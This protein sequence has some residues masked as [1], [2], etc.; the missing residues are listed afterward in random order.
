MPRISVEQYSFEKGQLSARFAN[1]VETETYRQGASKILHGLVTPQGSVVSRRGATARSSAPIRANH[2]V[3]P[4]VVADG[5]AYI[6]NVGIATGL[7]SFDLAYAAIDLETGNYAAVGGP[8]IRTSSSLTNYGLLTLNGNRKTGF[9][10]ADGSFFKYAQAGDTL[11][12]THPFVA[13]IRIVREPDGVGG[14]R[15]RA[16]ILDISNPPMDG[17]TAKWST[18]N[19]YPEAVAFH[20][21]R[22]WLG[23]GPSYPQTIWGSR[24][25]DYFNFDTSD[26]EDDY[27]IE[28]TSIT[29]E[30]DAIR[31]IVSG[32]HLILLTTD[33]EKYCPQE[34]ITPSNF[35]LLVISPIGATESV[36]PVNTQNGILYINNEENTLYELTYDENEGKYKQEALN[37]HAGLIDEPVYLSRA[38]SLQYAASERIH[39]S[40]RNGDVAVLSRATDTEILAWSL[41]PADDDRVNYPPIFL[42]VNN[43]IYIVTDITFVDNAETS[44]WKESTDQCCYEFT[45]SDN[46]KHVHNFRPSV[47][48]MP[49]APYIEGQSM[50]HRVKRI[51]RLWVH[52]E[53]CDSLEAVTESG[54]KHSVISEYTGEPVTG[55]FEIRMSGYNPY[56]KLTFRPKADGHKMRLLGWSAEVA[57][58]ALRTR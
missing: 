47:T 14:V 39:V 17:T 56:E 36:R 34:V 2:N 33:D 22:L 15:F 8:D 3:I 48:T 20:G 54:K 26:I 45:D 57:V 38:N 16:E 24:S 9:N 50:A 6:V 40:M 10:Q 31:H 27:G 7:L 53:E 28:F 18:S 23:G 46:V 49:I 51:V 1:R 43:E 35:T 37:I 13:P 11:I 12:L 42:E 55:R 32:P 5:A 30:I 52:A 25:H 58:E 29:R 19:G 41:W 44:I 21:G 4:F